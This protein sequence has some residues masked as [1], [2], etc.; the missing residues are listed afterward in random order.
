MRTPEMGD[1]VRYVVPDGTVRP[2]VVIAVQNAGRVALSIFT[3][4]DR[5]HRWTFAH[6]RWEPT[7]PHSIDRTPG[8]WHWAEH[9]GAMDTP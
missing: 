7:V 9:A 3:D 4:G 1:M 5:D 8:T 2:A 6:P